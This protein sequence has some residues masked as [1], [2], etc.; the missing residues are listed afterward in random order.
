[1]TGAVLL[2]ERIVTTVHAEGRGLTSI[3]LSDLAP[4]S[5]S[6]VRIEI[7]PLSTESRFWA[8]ASITNNA[9]Q[10]VTAITQAP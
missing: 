2:S 10:H 4:L 6:P 3:A 7:T 1:M 8:F 9:T 5:G